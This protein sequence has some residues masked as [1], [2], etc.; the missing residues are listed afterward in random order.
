MC[1]CKNYRKTKK[2]T[3]IIGTDIRIMIS[4]T[5]PK[6]IKPFHM[7]QMRETTYMVKEYTSEEELQD[8]I[9]QGSL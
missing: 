5:H 7:F 1:V 2:Y 4:L 9:I 6:I 8:L 3:L